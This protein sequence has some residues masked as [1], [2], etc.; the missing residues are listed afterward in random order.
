MPKS[1]HIHASSNSEDE[2]EKVWHLQGNVYV[3]VYSYS[4]SSAP[5]IGFNP[6]RHKL[7]PKSAFGMNLWFE[8]KKKNQ[9]QLQCNHYKFI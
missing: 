8:Y 2:V 5:L 9:T 1:E 4:N 3:Q 7:G 6:H